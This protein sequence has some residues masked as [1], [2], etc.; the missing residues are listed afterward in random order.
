[1]APAARHSYEEE[2][3]LIVD[4]AVKCVETSSIMDFTMSEI[5]KAAGISMGSVYKHIR[6]KEDVM[7]ALATEM[8]IRLLANF[9]TILSLPLPFPVRAIALHMTSEKA[10]H[11]YSFGT[12]LEMLVSNEAFLKRASEQWLQKLM[13]AD[14]AVENLVN[15]ALLDAVDNGELAADEEHADALAEEIMVATWSMCV[16]FFQVA[17]QRHTRHLVGKGIDMPFPLGVDDTIVQALKRLL[18][19]Y[20]WSEPVT[21]GAII[22]ACELLAANDLR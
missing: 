8:K 14:I 11:C 4:A 13:D 6:T 1:M 19:T 18:N 22:K 15:Q 21:D 12:E 16:G 2:Q 17:R 3:A 7:V 20:P 9:A 5:S 10:I